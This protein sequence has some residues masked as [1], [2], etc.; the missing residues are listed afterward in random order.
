MNMRSS[1]PDVSSR[2]EARLMAEYGAVFVT[3]AVPPSKILFADANEV[4]SFQ[5]SVD[6]LKQL[7]DPYWI[8]LQAKAM[9]ALQSAVAHGAEIGA[10]ITPRSAD[11]GGRSYEDTLALWRRNVAR[12]LEHWVDSGNLSA[13]QAE[14]IRSLSVTAQVETVLDL[15]D[16]H[17]IFFSTYFDKSILYSVAAPGASQHLSL[18]AFD[19]AEFTD[20]AVER[21]MAANGWYRTVMSDL[22]HFTYLGHPQSLLPDLG[23]ECVVRESDGQAYHFWIPRREDP[24]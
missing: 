15:E 14:A 17:Q 2:L 4:Q 20:G 19:V 24:R 8:E 21:V 6:K 7:F 12:G 5:D 9:N 1:K 10:S 18:L 23:L 3:A 11:A 13:E 22:P 16:S